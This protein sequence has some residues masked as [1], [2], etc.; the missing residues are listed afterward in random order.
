MRLALVAPTSLLCERKKFTI[1]VLEYNFGFLSRQ[2][3]YYLVK[4]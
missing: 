4:R 2:T 1:C 3:V